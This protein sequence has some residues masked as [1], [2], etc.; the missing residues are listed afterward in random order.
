LIIWHL[1]LTVIIG[2][3]SGGVPEGDY[4]HL[5]GEDNSIEFIALTSGIG[6]GMD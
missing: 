4:V 1:W 6:D 3:S 2:K 5:Y